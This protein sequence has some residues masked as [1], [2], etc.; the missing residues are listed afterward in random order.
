MAFGRVDSLVRR[1]QRK[2]GD[3]GQNKVERPDILDALTQTQFNIARDYLAL[4]LTGTLNL[5]VGVGA[6]PVNPPIY[7]L[8]SLTPPSNW[9]TELKLITDV[10]EWNDLISVPWQEKYSNWS[11]WIFTVSGITISPSVGSIWTNNGAQFTVIGTNLSGAAPSVSGTITCTGTNVPTTTG[12]LVLTSGAGDSQIDFSSV[13]PSTAQPYWYFVWGSNVNFWPVPSA[14]ATL[15]IMY[16]ALPATG[17]LATGTDPSLAQLWDDAL[18]LGAC[19]E[20]AGGAWRDLYLAECVKI[21]SQSLNE[22]TM[23]LRI[24]NLIEELGF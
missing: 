18:V 6:V 20:L 24:S 22:T 21:A 8:K 16:Y 12:S 23:P 19:D 1:V 14:S 4:K 13:Q 3:L 17:T 9:Q 11:Y 10:R 5:Q 7:R 2:F 15:N